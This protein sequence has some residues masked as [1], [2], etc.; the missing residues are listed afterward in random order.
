[1]VSAS[2]V[3]LPTPQAYN[4]DNFNMNFNHSISTFSKIAGDSSGFQ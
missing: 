4:P 2:P 3:Q 1:L